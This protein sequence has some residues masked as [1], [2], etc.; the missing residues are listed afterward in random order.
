MSYLKNMKTFKIT[1][2]PTA[3]SNITTKEMVDVQ[4]LNKL[5][6]SDLLRETFNNKYLSKIFK[7][8]LKQ[9]M[10]YKKMINSDGFIYIDMKKTNPFGRSHARLSLLQ[11]RREVRQTITKDLYT[12]VDIEN[13]HV[14]ILQQLCKKNKVQTPKLDDYINYREMYLMKLMNEYNINRDDAKRVFLV[15]MYCGNFLL[16]EDEPSYYKELVAETR[17]IAKHITE[18]NPDIKLMVE[19]MNEDVNATHQYISNINGKVLSHYLQ[20]FEHVILDEVFKYCT[21]KKYIFE[22]NCSLQADGI[23][24]PKANFKPSLLTELSK[25]IKKMLVLL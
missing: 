2:T 25:H 18:E 9:I 3:I 14:V 21:D 20:E 5:I 8:E 7:N 11:I 17:S 1:Q 22:N 6:S 23:M 12:D 4:M 15:A 24:I 13:A 16:E 19:K 10:E